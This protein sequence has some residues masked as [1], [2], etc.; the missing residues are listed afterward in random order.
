MTISDF[1]EI[2]LDYLR[3][4]CNFVGYERD[5]FELRGKGVPLETIAEKV[6]MSVDGIK[7]V[8]RK[9]NIKITKVGTFGTPTRH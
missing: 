4:N 8:S 1:T 7:K 9:V 2:E 5:V 6:N 3:R